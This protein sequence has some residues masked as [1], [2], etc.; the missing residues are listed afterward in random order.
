MNSVKGLNEGVEPQRV[1]HLAI[2][3]GFIENSQHWLCG[4]MTELSLISPLCSG[5]SVGEEEQAVPHPQL[6]SHTCFFGLSHN[7]TSKKP[8]LLTGCPTAKQQFMSHYRVSQ[9]VSI[10]AFIVIGRNQNKTPQDYQ[11]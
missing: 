6:S 3:Q 4:R 5:R 8:S 7:P 2:I 9:Q 1:R 10:G 11:D